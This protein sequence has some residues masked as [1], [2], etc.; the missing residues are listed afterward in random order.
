MSHSRRQ[1]PYPVDCF[2]LDGKG[3]QSYD[4][5]GGFIKAGESPVRERSLA[6]KTNKTDEELR[7]KG[8][9]DDGGTRRPRSEM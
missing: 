3:P 6:G 4:K 7:R 5:P 1:S 2:E 8:K 9:R